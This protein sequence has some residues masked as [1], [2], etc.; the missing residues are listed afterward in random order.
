VIGFD[1]ALAGLFANAFL[2]ATILPVASEPFALA[3]LAAGRDP[4]MVWAVASVANTAGA[5]V[6]WW[7]GRFAARLRERP[8]FP[9]GPDALARA[10]ACFARFGRPA[11]LLS[12]L[13]LV[14]D[15][16]TVVAGV[17]RTPLGPFL[18]LVAI[19]KAA[20]YAAVLFPVGAWLSP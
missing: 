11:L 7:L 19:G 8:G 12:W 16:L 15:A 2:A 13:P 5:V 17:L 1:P 14:G 4:W 10:E 20:R 18:V 3:L 9:V 6:G